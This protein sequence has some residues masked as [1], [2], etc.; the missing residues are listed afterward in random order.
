MVGARARAQQDGP[1]AGAA[2]AQQPD[3]NAV[4]AKIAQELEAKKVKKVA[5][6][7]FVG[8]GRDITA[9]GVK[10][11]DDFSAALSQSGPDLRVE[12][13]TVVSASSKVS[14]YRPQDLIDPGSIIP[15]GSFLN[16]DADVLGSISVDNGQILVSIHALQLSRTGVSLIDKQDVIIPASADTAT[17]LQ[18]YVVR[19][20]TE[21]GGKDDLSAVGMDGYS[22]PQ[23]LRCGQAK[24]SDAALKLRL[25]G[26]VALSV[27]VTT[28]GTT[29]DI[30]VIKG[31]GAGLD[32]KAVEAV[33]QWRLRPATTPEG[34][35]VAVRQIILISFHL[36]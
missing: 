18:T 26:I 3:V 1:S 27:V 31:L 35:P 19:A 16:L 29:K 7:D 22:E 23:C 28:D 9:L 14:A 10:L 17:L 5:V 32:E 30:H 34:R 15:L 12:S 6:F 2:N 4:A 21:A 24:Y 8:P 13:R 25:E 11:A 20:T 36:G 33:R